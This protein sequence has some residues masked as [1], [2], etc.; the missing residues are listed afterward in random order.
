MDIRQKTIEYIESLLQRAEI[1]LYGHLL[2]ENERLMRHIE[3]TKI[4][5]NN[6]GSNKRF[7]IDGTPEIIQI[8]LDDIFEKPFFNYQDPINYGT[9]MQIIQDI[10]GAANM[11]MP[12]YIENLQMPIVATIENEEYNAKFLTKNRTGEKIEPALLFHSGI[13]TFSEIISDVYLGFLDN[14][15]INGKNEILVGDIPKM[16]N[17]ENLLFSFAYVIKHLLSVNHLLGMP[18]VFGDHS[19]RH[20]S[21]VFRH[22]ILIFIAAHEYSHYVFEYTDLD[23]DPM[24]TLSETDFDNT[25]RLFFESAWKNE[26]KADS[27]ALYLT[28]SVGKTLGYKKSNIC[29]GI[30]LAITILDILTKT[31]NLK[32]GIDIDSSMVLTE[33]HPPINMRKDIIGSALVKR[34]GHNPYSLA[35]IE[36]FFYGL[37]EATWRHVVQTEL[38]FRERGYKFYTLSE[39][40]HSLKDVIKQK[41]IEFR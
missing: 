10:H 39:F 5:I 33:T 24:I 25:Q 27:L 14:R 1:K 12:K 8:L 15:E 38:V 3:G 16:L 21:H 36:S 28:L 34:H 17:N 9:M 7:E 26:F 32:D 23:Y 29:T 22:C 35:L 19:A 11:A 20:I 31:Q 37:W 6:F 40:A 18:Y 41:T 4:F 13:F 2:D 30:F